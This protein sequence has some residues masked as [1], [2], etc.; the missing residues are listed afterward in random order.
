M[1][2][3]FWN[4]CQVTEVRRPLLIIHDAVGHQKY[5]PLKLNTVFTSVQF[6]GPLIR[7]S[8]TLPDLPL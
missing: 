7:R 3:Y 2:D 1:L 5:Q 6:L 4:I 8:V